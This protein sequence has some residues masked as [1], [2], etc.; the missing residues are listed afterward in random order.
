MSDITITDRIAGRVSPAL[1]VRR[2]ARLQEQGRHLRSFSLLAAVATRGHGEAQYYMGMSYLEGKVVPRSMSEAVG[3]LRKAAE[4]GVVRSQT[5]LAALYVNGKAAADAGPSLE[6]LFDDV[7]TSTPSTG[8]PKFE[9]AAKWARKAAEAGSA[10]GQALLAYILTNGPPSLRDPDA[11]LRWYRQS[12]NGGCAQG[13]LGY[14]LALAGRA[15]DAATKAEM[16]RHL[17]R[18]ADADLA[19]AMFLLAHL[20]EHG[21]VIPKD[22]N[23][24][25]ALYRKAAMR[26]HL[27]SQSRLGALLSSNQGAPDAT[28]EGE[29]WLHRA[30]LGGDVHAQVLLAQTYL[31]R[32]QSP[33]DAVRWFKTAAEAG[34][35]YAAR[36][37]SALYCAGTDDPRDQEEAQ[38]WLQRAA[39]LGDPRAQAEVANLIV[40]GQTPLNESVVHQW[41]AESAGKGDPIG[42]FNLGI[43]FAEGIGTPRDDRRAAEYFRIAAEELPEAQY[44]FGRALAQ[45][46]GVECDPERAREYLERAAS[47]GI[48]GAQ[49]ALAEM[50]MNG[51]GGPVDLDRARTL[52]N[53]AAARGHS[54]AMF[55]LGALNSGSYGLPADLGAAIRWFRAAASRGHEQAK[56][57]ARR[58]GA[59]GTLQ[60]RLGR[61]RPTT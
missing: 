23:G 1:A 40:Q 48:P 5:L 49:A 53:A 45:G 2:A 6:S 15:S 54:G 55:A 50:L 3:W 56:S 37:L 43:A 34:H 24:A 35:A 47:A 29:E 26:H 31:E 27:A 32:H 42:I 39:E 58:Y 51:R 57:L 12:A 21:E 9:E 13:H 33:P 17:E 16:C 44:R 10:D 19:T 4:A 8:H 52:L 46:H 41:F 25:I 18:A 36:C 30:A 14:A 11:A 38:H 60:P 59:R 20:K 28:T 61:E 7:F 22:L